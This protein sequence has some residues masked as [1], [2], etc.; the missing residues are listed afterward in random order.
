MRPAQVGASSPGPPPGPTPA[1]ES[2][3]RKVVGPLNS[4]PVSP[5]VQNRGRPW[6]G[7]PFSQWTGVRER[8]PS[9]AAGARIAGATESAA[10]GKPGVAFVVD[11]GGRSVS[12]E[13]AT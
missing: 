2:Q 8:V 13:T 10:L 11:R 7:F 5:R 6:E 4:L 1:S 3:I 9:G 12:P